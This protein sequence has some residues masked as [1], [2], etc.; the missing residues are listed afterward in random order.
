MKIIDFLCYAID[1]RSAKRLVLL[2]QA[3]ALLML[4]GCRTQLTDDIERF[5]PV[6]EGAVYITISDGCVELRDHWDPELAK[7]WTVE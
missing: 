3:V 1:G 4:V 6:G 5:T 2:A 7:K